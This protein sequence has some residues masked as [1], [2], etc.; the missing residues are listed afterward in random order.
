VLLLNNFV[1]TVPVAD[2][3]YLYLHKQIFISLKKN[4]ID[5]WESGYNKKKLK[6]MTIFKIKINVVFLLNNFVFYMQKT[7]QCL[8]HTCCRFYVFISA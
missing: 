1:C 3:M 6:L 4:Y 7:I 2:F 5:I 8:H